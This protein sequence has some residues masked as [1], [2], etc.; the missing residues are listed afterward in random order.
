MTYPD[1][2]KTAAQCVSR[3]SSWLLPRIG[4]EKFEFRRNFDKNETVL[5]PQFLL[6]RFALDHIGNSAPMF[7]LAGFTPSLES[8]L[9]AMHERPERYRH[10]VSS[11]V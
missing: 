6:E 1:N 4:P 10:L 5:P 9:S 3:L 11:V 7:R 8:A 2:R